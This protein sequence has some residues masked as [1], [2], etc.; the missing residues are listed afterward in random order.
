[1]SFSKK[2]VNGPLG[3]LQ[4]KS[5]KLKAEVG[6]YIFL[7]DGSNTHKDIFPRRVKYALRNMFAQKLFFFTKGHFC[8]MTL[9]Q[10]GS[11]MH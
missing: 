6:V 9:I 7:R 4:K 3:Q 8:K 5:D 11:D 2:R 10:E 1:M